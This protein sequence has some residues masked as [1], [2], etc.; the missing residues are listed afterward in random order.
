[1]QQ[2]RASRISYVILPRRAAAARNNQYAE[3]MYQTD[4]AI[5][6][7]YASAREKENDEFRSWLKDKDGLLLDQVVHNINDTVSAG[8]DC[9]ACGNCCKTLVIDVSAAEMATCAAHLHMPQE[10]FK[11]QYLEESQQGKLYISTIP[12]HFLADNKCTIYANRFTDCRAFPHLYKDGFRDRLPGTLMHY[13]KCPIVYNVLE[14][15]K[16]TLGYPR[17]DH[18]SPA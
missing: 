12:C 14:E 16:D 1:M 7:T 15:L 3:V 8:I 4:L 10:T 13:G 17:Q 9:T 11:E 2:A 5:I 6:A 18:L